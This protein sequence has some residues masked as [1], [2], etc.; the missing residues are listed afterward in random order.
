[1]AQS[2]G[3]RKPFYLINLHIKQ[4]AAAIQSINQSG[5]LPSRGK[6]IQYIYTN[7]EHY[8]PLSRVI[9][10]EN[11][12]DKV[13]YD[14]EKYKEMLLDAAENALTIFGF[15]RTMYGKPKDKKWWIELRRNRMRDVRAEGAS[16]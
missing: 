11:L 5:K 6:M 9:V 2:R 13:D 3:N 1:V 10:T 16:S 12:S 14:R 15:D 7:T 4:V 8:N